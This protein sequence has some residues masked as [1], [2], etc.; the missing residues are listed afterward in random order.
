VAQHIGVD[1]DSQI[2][3]CDNAKE[4]RDQEAHKDSAIILSNTVVDIRAV[5]LVVFCHAF[6][7]HLQARQQQQQ[8]QQQGHYNKDTE[9]IHAY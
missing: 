1:G 5:M 6:I 7:A 4:T 3:E 2:G 9:H 8:Q